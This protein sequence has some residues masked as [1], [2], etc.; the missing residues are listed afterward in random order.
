[1]N[2]D[3]KIIEKLEY[4]L[5]PNIIKALNDPAVYEVM[6]N[7]DNRLWEDRGGQLNQIGTFS[8]THAKTL[9][10]TVASMNDQLVNREHPDLSAEIPFTINGN[11]TLL[12]FQAVMPPI[13]KTYIFSIRKPASRVF[14]LKEYLADGVINEFQFNYLCSAIA[15]RKNLIIAGSTSSGK[16]TFA[17][18]LLAEIVNQNPKERICLIEDTYEL[19]CLAEN[20][21]EL[22]VSERRDTWDLL[23]NCLRL[24]PDRLIIGEIRGR[25]VTAFLMALNTGH[26]GSIT[27]IHANDAHSALRRIEQLI[28]ENNHTPIRDSIALA[29]NVVVFISKSQDNRAGRTVREIIEVN[30]YD[31]TAHSYI[32]TRIFNDH[33]TAIDVVGPIS[34]IF[35]SA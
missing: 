2:L 8:N 15:E 16:S 11:A 34:E 24:R 12:R 18:A 31:T 21:V 9:I 30:G 32:T 7:G 22:K 4:I 27:T 5:G 35:E 26:S 29:V 25:E 1:M 33:F 19:Q 20:R 10:F 14:S 13:T 23:R 3:I 17:N 6:L 28:E